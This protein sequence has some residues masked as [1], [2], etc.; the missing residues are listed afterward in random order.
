ML[1]GKRAWTELLAGREPAAE[2]IG[3]DGA[4]NRS[5][6]I[7]GLCGLAAHLL[8]CT[9]RLTPDRVMQQSTFGKESIFILKILDKDKYRLHTSREGFGREG[10]AR[11]RRTSRSGAGL[12]PLHRSD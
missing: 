7:S 8:F 2:H 6:E 10:A 5:A 3:A 4:K 1:C 11:L 12:P 9:G